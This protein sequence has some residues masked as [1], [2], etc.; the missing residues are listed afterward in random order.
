MSRIAVKK[1]NDDIEKFAQLIPLALRAIGTK[2][3]QGGL[4]GAAKSAAKNL[5]TSMLGSKLLGGGGQAPSSTQNS[6]ASSS[7][8]TS[9]SDNTEAGQEDNAQLSPSQQSPAQRAGGAAMAIGQHFAQQQQMQQQ[10]NQQMAEKA[11]QGSQIQTGEPMDMS[12]RLLKDVYFNQLYNKPEYAQ[13]RQQIIDAAIENMQNVQYSPDTHARIRAGFPGYKPSYTING[14]NFYRDEFDKDIDARHPE[15]YMYDQEHSNQKK[16]PGMFNIPSY[17]LMDAMKNFVDWDNLP[18]ITEG[19]N[20]GQRKDVGIENLFG[21]GKPHQPQEPFRGVLQEKLGGLPSVITFLGR[22]MKYK[23]ESTETF[24]HS[25][26]MHPNLERGQNLLEANIERQKENER[27]KAEAEAEAIRVKEEQRIKEENR[28]KREAIYRANRKK[29]KLADEAGLTVEEWEKAEEERI[30]REKEEEKARKKAHYD[31][32]FQERM[33]EQRRSQE[34]KEQIEE[35]NKKLDAEIETL[36]S[37]DVLNT[38]EGREIASKWYALPNGAVFYNGGVIWSSNDIKK[39][40]LSFKETALAIAVGRKLGYLKKS[41]PMDLAWQLLKNE[42]QLPLRLGEKIRED[43]MALDRQHKMVDNPDGTLIQNIH[44]DMENVVKLLTNME[45][46][47]QPVLRPPSR[48]AYL[49]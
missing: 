45:A 23:P 3:A 20:I 17:H 7:M 22:G 28:R 4:K 2:V 24:H 29:K 40:P 14:R 49:F 27:M 21:I 13:A 10:N 43:V 15:D 16:F 8:A 37:Q 1:G 39:L 19:E 47:K 18:L 41:E 25:Y 46:D 26:F 30:K 42:L 35:E 5:G 12:W 9:G 44:P 32:M 6:M 36:V 11:K 38:E 34:L 33:E 48:P 31:Q